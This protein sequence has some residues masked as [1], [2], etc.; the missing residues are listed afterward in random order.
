MSRIVLFVVVLAVATSAGLAQAG[1][2]MAFFDRGEF[3]DF[4]KGQG[5]S[6]EGIET[7][8]ESNIP[9]GGKVPLPAPLDQN[10]NTFF[11]V[12]FPN[13][14]NQQNIAIWDNVTPGPN[15]PGL[16]PSGN[17]FALYVVGVG[18]LEAK[19]NKVGSDLF[20][21][22]IQASLDLA[23]GDPRYSGV[24]FELSWFMGYDRA[25]WDVSIY[26]GQGDTIGGVQFQGPPGPEPQTTFFGIWCGGGI[27]RINIY[28][29][30]GP[31]PDAIA[32]IEMWL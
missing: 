15:P 22:G 23:F 13:G 32:N 10:P 21:F 5:K 3:R 24:G 17:M 12:G 14:L 18:F 11:G 28:D 6:M 9:P 20:L 26:N 27:G 1:T 31:A 25:N 4:N 16:N 2:C 8:E 19:S 29:N 30:S 7:F